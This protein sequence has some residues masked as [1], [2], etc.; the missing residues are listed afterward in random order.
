MNS[1][2]GETM[3]MGKL[4]KIWV[5]YPLEAV[6]AVLLFSIFA[7]LPVGVAS[8]VGGFVGRNLGPLLPV[9]RRGRLNLEK[10]MPE[11]TPDRRRQILR[12]M[13]DNLGRIIAEY[14]H[15]RTI[16]RDAGRGGRVDVVGAENAD[17]IRFDGKP[18]IFFSAHLANWEVFAF[19]MAAVGLE[20]AQVY[21]AP[22]N[23]LIARMIH[24]V[25]GL[26]ADRQIPKGAA[27]A[28]MAISTLKAG[29]RVA[30]LVDQK[31]NDGVAAPFFGRDAMS[32]PAVAQLG[33]RHDC[34]VVP[35]RLERI[36]GCQFRLTLYPPFELV[37]TGNRR[38]DAV[39]TMTRV[40]ELL[41]SWIRERPE[42]WLWL[43]RRW[44][45]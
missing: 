39:A 45:D 14:P 32:P 17:A 31:M 22:N 3:T 41:E 12:A 16:A 2:P 33:L 20:F 15:I 40:N 7:V 21:R 35:M 26:P 9:N 8:A 29:G 44:P 34:V 27:G 43:H 6:A 24:L 37:R 42:Q 13:W 36:G 28:R 23:R 10:A 4:F 11:T 5:R 30:M 38:A 25:R 19:A 18:G 1:S